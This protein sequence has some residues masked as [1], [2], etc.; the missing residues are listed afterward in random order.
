MPKPN[1][2][3]ETLHA[4]LHDSRLNSNG[5]EWIQQVHDNRPSLFIQLM[6]SGRLVKR[7]LVQQELATDMAEQLCL[8]EGVP[9]MMAIFTAQR[10]YI[11]VPTKEHSPNLTNQG[12][13]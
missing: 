12:G 11:L 13:S 6:M 5:C 9:L 8:H 4:A 2:M 10:E 1:A 7:A 3:E